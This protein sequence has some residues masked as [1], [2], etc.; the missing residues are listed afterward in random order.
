MSVNKPT[1]K[2]YWIVAK[3]TWS[4]ILT[5]R[6]NFIIWRVRW[7]ISLLT[8][9]FLWFTLLPQNVTIQS[10]NQTLIL[11]YILGTSI[12][13]SLVMS[14]RTFDVGD[15]INKGNLSVFL[16]RPI[17]YF[18]Y[19]FSKD[20]G[21]K[22]MNIVFCIFELSILI[23]ILK[24]PI[25]VQTNLSFLLPFFISL[26]VALILYFFF[27]FLIGFFGFWTPDVWAPRFIFTILIGFFA[28]GL[29]PLDL[30]PKQIFSVFQYLPFPYLMFFPLKIYLGQL[31]QLEILKGLVI[32]FI[33]M[34]IMYKFLIAIW[35]KGLRTYTAQGI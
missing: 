28:G 1:F 19:N 2:K 34:I 23:L 18:L 6:L 7:V 27:N 32:S 8:M 10:Y 17:N 15:Q 35:K 11:T 14:S 25:F 5:Y 31:S 13:G 26:I 4:E 20:I 9:Y 22:A 30:M 24:P 33:W 12:I 16:I 21:D 3:N 29:F